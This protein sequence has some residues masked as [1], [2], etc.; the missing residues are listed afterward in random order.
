MIQHWYWHCI[1]IMSVQDTLYYKTTQ[2]KIPFSPHLCLRFFSKAATFA[3]PPQSGAKMAGSLPWS[4]LTVIILRDRATLLSML[5]TFSTNTLYCIRIT[6]RKMVVDRWNYF[7]YHIVGK[8]Y[9]YCDDIL[10]NRL[11][12]TLL[13]FTTKNRIDF[14]LQFRTQFY[15]VETASHSADLILQNDK[16]FFEK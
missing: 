10:E 6:D 4:L 11:A 15:N 7:D 16:Q 8:K 5:P 9:T 2:Y 3:G 1:N 12:P 14:L 13:V